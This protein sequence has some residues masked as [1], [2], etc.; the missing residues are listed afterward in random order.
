MKLL[1]FMVCSDDEVLKT[2]Y[3]ND[4][5]MKEIINETKKIAG[6]EKMDLYLTDEELMKQDQEYYFNKGIQEKEKEMVIAF[7]NNGVSLDIIS[8]S[9]GLTIDEVKRIVGESK[10]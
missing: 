7:Y 9:S 5:I 3:Q 6:I 4:D 8:K 10:D 1:Y 2:V